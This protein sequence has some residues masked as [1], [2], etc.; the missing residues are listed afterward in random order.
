MKF[1]RPSS[2]APSQVVQVKR[3]WSI[4]LEVVE[5]CN[6]SC[7][8]CGIHSIRSKPNW[9]IYHEMPVELVQQMFQETQRWLPGGVRVELDNHGEP[10]LHS[11]FPEIVAAIRQDPHAHIQLQTNCSQ[12]ETWEVFQERVDEWFARGLNLLALNTYKRWWGTPQGANRHDHFLEMARRYGAARNIPV[13]DHYYDNP[14]RLSIYRRYPTNKQQIFVLDDLGEVNVKARQETGR[15]V[16]KDIN[17]EA[18]NTPSKPL[19]NLL[20]QPPVDAPLKKK[21]T[22]PFRELN[23]GYN[24]VVPVCCYDWSTQMPMGKFPNQSLQQIWESVQMQTVRELLYRKNRHMTPCS[25]CSY[26]GG[27]RQGLLTPP[28]LGGTDASLQ[29]VLKEHLKAMRQYVFPTAPVE[30]AGQ[31]IPLHTLKRSR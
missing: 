19:Q 2:S 26:N 29:L 24:G 14:K 16:S 23:M 30:V 17:N 28:D 22:R 31:I 15:P 27:W 18:G 12:I 8:F 21:C 9:E 11:R 13:V 7:W 5:G 20:G 4:Q 3:P 25:V 6:Y 1:K 10:T